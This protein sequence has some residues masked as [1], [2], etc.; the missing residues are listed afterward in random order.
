MNDSIRGRRPLAPADAVLDL[1]SRKTRTEQICEA[2]G[3]PAST[4]KTIVRQYRLRG[5]VRAV[6]R[7]R[8]PRPIAIDEFISLKETAD[9]AMTLADQ[10]LEFFSDA[11]SPECDELADAA[12][13]FRS[14]LREIMRHAPSAGVPM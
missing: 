13:G 9:A 10:I 3:V 14:R 4:V 1:W 6:S 12:A 2:L 7:K 8:G 11:I 5:D